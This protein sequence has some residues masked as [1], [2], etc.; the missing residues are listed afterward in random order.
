M[1]DYKLEEN[2]KYIDEFHLR[3]IGKLVEDVESELRH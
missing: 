3:N 2:D 1:V